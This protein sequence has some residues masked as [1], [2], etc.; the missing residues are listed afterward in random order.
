MENLY[1]L[2]VEAAAIQ[3]GS[4]LDPLTAAMMRAASAMLQSDGQTKN[5]EEA[6]RQAVEPQT[7]TTWAKL[8]ES[9]CRC[10]AITRSNIA[11]PLL[12]ADDE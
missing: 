4:R 5:T 8:Q 12:H 9:K 7:V 2:Y 1:R 3:S 10:S 11:R 6:R